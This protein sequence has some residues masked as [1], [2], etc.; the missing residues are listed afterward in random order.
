MINKTFINKTSGEKVQIIKEDNN[1]YT[2]DDGVKIK[3]DTFNNR[4]EI[5]DKI[6]PSTFLKSESAIKNLADDLKKIDTSNIGE[7]DDKTRI[8]YKPGITISDNSIQNAPNQNEGIKISESQKQKMIDEYNM[9]QELGE[10]SKKPE[11]TT[12]EN[13]QTYIEYNMPELDGGKPINKQQPLKSPFQQTQI[14][15]LQMMF[16]MFKNNYDVN[17][18][19]ELNEKIANPQFIQMVMENVDGDAIDYYSKIILEKLLKEPLKL[20]K[21]IYNQLKIEVYGKDYVEKEKLEKEKLEK[22]KKE[23]D[24]ND[25]TK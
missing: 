12:D 14:D 7:R 10:S 15:P 25:E 20:K 17:I 3:K 5:S 1:F 21:E 16:N 24:N 4:Y 23:K 6:D 2:L 9:K 22:L 13:N 19:L 11:F 8:K 18:K